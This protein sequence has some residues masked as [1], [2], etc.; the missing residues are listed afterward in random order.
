MQDKLYPNRKR[1]LLAVN[2]APSGQT[3]T[4]TESETLI[5][6][7]SASQT[8]A[9]TKKR[10]ATTKTT[11]LEKNKGDDE[12]DSFTGDNHIDRVAAENA[13]A[14]GTVTSTRFASDNQDFDTSSSAGCKIRAHAQSWIQAANMSGSFWHPTFVDSGKATPYVSN[15]TGGSY[16]SD[17]KK[18][19]TFFA[20]SRDPSVDGSVYNLQAPEMWLELFQ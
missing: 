4:E 13:R 10:L 5:A 11:T 1:N 9:N 18:G 2:V 19:D 17:I 14:A 3:Q 7:A 16:G 20:S 15:I 6:A 8:E 12:D